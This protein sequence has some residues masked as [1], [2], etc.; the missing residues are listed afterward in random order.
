MENTTKILERKREESGRKSEEN[1]GKESF[2][3]P[4]KTTRTKS[5]GTTATE[6]NR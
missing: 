1:I 4:K 3:T 2:E 6:F 5:R